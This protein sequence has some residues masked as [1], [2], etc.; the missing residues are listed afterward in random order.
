MNWLRFRG[1]NAVG[2]EE[3]WWGKWVWS[4]IWSETWNS[5]RVSQQTG[6]EFHYKLELRYKP[7]LKQAQTR[8]WAQIQLELGSNSSST[9][10]SNWTRILITNRTWTD[11]KLEF[12]HKLNLHLNSGQAPWPQTWVLLQIGIEQTSFL[13][14]TTTSTGTDLFLEFCYKLN[15]NQP[16]SFYWFWRH[17][18]IETNLRPD[19]Y[20]KLKLNQPVFQFWLQTQSKLDSTSTLG[21][22]WTWPDLKLIQIKLTTFWIPTAQWTFSVRFFWCCPDWIWTWLF[23]DSWCKTE[24]DWPLLKFRVRI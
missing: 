11:L 1:G 23:L 2:E 14:L 24:L 22:N 4:W 9:T 18:K 13:M 7:K 20:Y 16:L 15:L 17:S 10:N 6:L 12:H 5:T 3:K 19:F 8:L 21:I